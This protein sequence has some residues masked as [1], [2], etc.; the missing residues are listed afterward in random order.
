MKRLIEF[1]VDNYVLTISVFGALVLFGVVSGLG[2][3][4]NLFPEIEVPVVAVSTA[5]PG[6]GP[7]EISRQ[8]VE[9]IEGT[10]ATLPGITSVSSLSS[11]GFG[12]VIAQFAADLGVDQAAVDVSQRVNQIAGQLP[13]G[14]QTPAV[15]KFDPNDLPILNVA[16]SAPGEALAEVQAYA[17][18]E[19][20]PQL[21][22]VEGVADVSI[23]GPAEREV[24]VLLDPA[25][26][27]RYG[28]GPQQVVGAIGAATPDVPAGSLT[29]GGE[30]ILLA[31]RATPSSLADI[32]DIRVDSQRG[33]RVLDV[34]TVRD[35]TGDVSSY[36]RL[37]GEPV[38]VLE[39]RKVSGS[40]A[41]ATAANLRDALA[42]I[43]LP[44]GYASRIVGDST[45]FVAASVEDTLLETLISALAVSFVVLLFVGRL[46]SV[47]AV[48]LAIPV[49]LAGAVIVFQFFGFTF[50]IITLLALTVAIGLVV[51]DAIVVA[52]SIDR[53]REMGYGLR[54][55]VL[56]GASEVGTAVLAATLSLLAVFIP[57][58]LLPGIVGQFFA[59][60]GITMAAAIV[61]SYLEAMFFLTVRLALS[62]DPFPPGWTELPRA[63]RKAGS[64]LRWTL[65]APR[66]P[67]FWLGVLAAGAAVWVWLEPPQVLLLLLAL[68]LLWLLRYGGRLL[69]GVLGALALNLYQVGNWL[70][71][72]SRAAYVAS[73]AR[74]L[75]RP[76]WVLGLA[77]GLFASLFWVFP[78]IGFNFQPPSDS[79]QLNFSLELPAG[80]SLERTDGLAG[81]LEA[82]LLASPLVETV[83]VAVGSG[84]VL[85]GTDSAQASFTVELVGREERGASTDELA[86]V[87]EEEARAALAAYPEA[88]LRVSTGDEATAPPG[89]STGYT[90]LLTS[91]DLDLLQQRT[92]QALAVLGQNPNLRN[93]RSD[94]SER[95]SE[96]VFVVRPAQLDGTGLSVNDIYQALRTYNVGSEAGRLR[97]AGDEL[98]IRVRVNPLAVQDEQT[99]LSLPIYAP[100]LQ[101]S[102]PL[103]QLGAFE[104]RDAPSTISR[105]QQAYSAQL[106][107]DIVTGVPLSQVS[108]EARRSLQAAGVLDARVS[109][110]TVSS[111]DLL[112]DLLFYGP[113]AFALALLLNYLAIGS[114]FNSFKY[115]LY[116]LLTVPLA[117]VGAIWLFYLTGTSLDVISILGVVM[118]VGLVTKNAILLLDVVLQRL[119]EGARDLRAA[120]LE[121]AQVRF[122]PIIMTT[123]TV[124]VI[125]LPLL[126]GFG[127]GSEFR[128]P[129]GLVILGGVLSSAL[130]TF[131]VVPA[132]F[133]QFERGR[134]E[135]PGGS[136]RAEEEQVRAEQREGVKAEVTPLS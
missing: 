24:Q 57:I 80:T 102:L 30:R 71:A 4:V 8:V 40:N 61:F 90:T 17:E 11:E 65:A 74:A 15:Q 9:P 52:E 94:S 34:A 95:A 130:L 12:I 110:E 49:S 106:S 20:R 79:G 6:A 42:E 127:E 128:Y 91:N 129:L 1:F 37:N 89:T 54:E 125:S 50:N 73:L 87:F 60:F 135:G 84:T 83:Q 14:V 13:D 86:V 2:R 109:E 41:V 66:R 22:N 85:G 123:L 53:Y 70:V 96:R 97:Q 112:E 113:I 26:L 131:Y 36:A 39:V 136:R 43:D 23:I 122:R 32:E 92:E 117:L 81:L 98:P 16:L 68:P 126:L 27:E 134:I 10:L 132:A 55:A 107:A 101:A 133:Y 63:A 29:V 120:L 82:E 77:L 99:L 67:W 124:V 28:L 58:S 69:A 5:Y 108:D 51:D 31:G 119:A 35:S 121:A 44:A 75:Q 45:V 3:G 46:G 78:R 100:A 116:L 114:Q 105:E 38:I 33:V 115:P 19:L 104:T 25:R 111:I 56:R 118:L 64:D 103:G 18:N 76:L 7:E 93:L 21:Q 48:V 59:E 72:R 88:E 62:P 47:F